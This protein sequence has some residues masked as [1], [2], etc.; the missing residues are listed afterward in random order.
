MNLSNSKEKL[1]SCQCITT[2][3]GEKK[4][5]EKLV[6]R[7]LLRLQDY[8]RKFAQGHWSFVGPGVEKKWY[9]THVYN[10]NGECDDVADIMM[11]NFSES[12]H[13]DPVH[14]MEISRAGEKE[15]YPYISMA[16]TKPSK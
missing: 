12:G 9:G 14:L 10:P 3:C 4:E 6:L 13:P 8:A 16:A 1:S 15:N 11:S 2:L 7:T 5:T